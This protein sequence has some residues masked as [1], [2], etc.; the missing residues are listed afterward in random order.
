[1]SN[2]HGPAGTGAWDRWRTARNTKIKKPTRLRHSMSVLLP[3][4]VA[5]GDEPIVLDAPNDDFSLDSRKS[6]AY[7]GA[8]AAIGTL[9]AT[10]IPRLFEH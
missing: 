10:L 2:P 7:G 8:G 4:G 6:D 9:P 1:M 3:V 5:A